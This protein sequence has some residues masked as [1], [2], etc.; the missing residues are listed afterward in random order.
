MELNELQKQIIFKIEG[1]FLISAPV[2]TGKTTVLAERVINAV[3]LGIKSEEI[4]CLT[5]TNRTAEE[6][7]QRIRQKLSNKQV[8]D[9]LTVKTFHGFCA[10]FIKAEAKEIGIPA[11][12]VIFDD[13]DQVETMKKALENHP[14]I[15][16]GCVSGKRGLED[17]IEKLYNYRLNILKSKIGCKMINVSIDKVLLEINNSYLACTHFF[18]HFCPHN[19]TFGGKGIIL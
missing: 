5:F 10:Y 3:S 2:G 11:D 12:F 6:M 13:E 19:S 4:L 18:G 15:L 17:L 1:A 14:E 9:A 16:A 8:F 7:A